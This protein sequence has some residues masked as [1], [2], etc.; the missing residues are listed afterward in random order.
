[1]TMPATHSHAPD[2][3]QALRELI[4]GLDPECEVLVDE[5]SGDVLVRGSIDPAQLEAV[6]MTTAASDGSLARLRRNLRLGGGWYALYPPPRAFQA[7]G[8][9]RFIAAIRESNGDPIPPQLALHFDIPAAYRSSFCHP[10][11]RPRGADGSRAEAY[12]DR[13]VREVGLVGSQILRQ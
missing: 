10:D 4:A 3:I 2:P 8:D 5:I 1:M 11:S 7:F 13:L 9:D 12:R 6:A